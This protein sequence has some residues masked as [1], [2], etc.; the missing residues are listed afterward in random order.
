MTLTIL[1]KTSQTQKDKC[2]CFLSDGSQIYQVLCAFVY[3]VGHITSKYSK[4]REE[5]FIKW[6]ERKQIGLQQ[7]FL[8]NSPPTLYRHINMKA[9][10][11]T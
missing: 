10:P 7:S 11:V 8:D 3:V 2:K 4:G 5:E 9:Q 6:V 1:N